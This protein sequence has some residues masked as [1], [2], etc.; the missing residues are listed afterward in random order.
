[1][2][3]AAW[4]GAVFFVAFLA[5][6]LLGDWGN[7]TTD[8]VGK[9]GARGRGL[10]MSGSVVLLSAVAFTLCVCAAGVAHIRAR[11]SDVGSSVPTT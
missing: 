8:D 4:C 3:A 11:R 9:T 10:V 5:Y 1:M 2:V 6:G 7:T